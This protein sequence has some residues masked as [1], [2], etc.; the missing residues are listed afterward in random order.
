MDTL[1]AI[2]LRKSV[3]TYL[4]KPVEAEKIEQLLRAGNS[5][6]KVGFFHISVIENPEVLKEINEQALVQYKNSGDKLLM[7][8]AAVEGYQPLYGAPVFFLFSAPF[9]NPSNEATTSCAV[10]SITIAA[11][12]LGLGSCYIHSALLGIK[13]NPKLIEKIGIPFGL[14]PI[15]G[16][17]VGYSAEEPLP[18]PQSAEENVN[19]C[20]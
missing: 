15:C 19:Y 5:A 16:V 4:P 14:T 2:E 20:R 11:T 10:T 18:S 1:K 7:G 13:G 12:A 17:V 6:P 3:R 8:P 9:A